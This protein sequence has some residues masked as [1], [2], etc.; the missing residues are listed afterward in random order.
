[1]IRRSL[2][3]NAVAVWALCATGL[4]GQTALGPKC[5]SVLY[6]RLDS[7]LKPTLISVL[8]NAHETVVGFEVIHG[9]PVVA[10]PHSLLTIQRVGGTRFAVD[11]TIKGLSFDKEAK[12][13]IQSNKGVLQLDRS[14]LEPDNK[15][16]SVVLGRVYGSGGK[17][18]LE[19]RARHGLL[20]FLA[21]RDDGAA[22]PIAMMK[23]R[24]RAVSWNSQGL[25]AVVGE[26]LYLWHPGDKSVVRLLSDEGLAS[27]HDVVALGGGRAVVALRNAIVL[28]SP[29][30]LDII[31]AMPLSRCRFQDGV[32]YVL[33]EKAGLIWSLRGLEKL[34]SKV[35]DEAYAH[36]LLERSKRDTAHRNTEIAEA[37]RILG[38]GEVKKWLAATNQHGGMVK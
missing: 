28:V 23:G 26:S 10:F 4:I 37:A 21:R 5:N 11:Q 34:G 19:V 35:D 29:K 7:R 1:M 2:Y 24:L 18:L 32:L 16:N 17:V 20:E 13:F 12:V 9:S 30:T 25:A 8:P 3:I 6:A 27:S 14:G 33:Q 38:C 36:G 15:L 22:F 31:A